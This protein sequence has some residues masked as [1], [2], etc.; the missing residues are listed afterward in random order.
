[1][2][3]EL[4]IELKVQD[5][6][7]NV[8]KKVCR[9]LLI[10]MSLVRNNIKRFDEDHHCD[11]QGDDQFLAMSFFM[12]WLLSMPSSIFHMPPCREWS[13]LFSDERSPVFSVLKTLH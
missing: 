4:K 11:R 5:H 12:R 8:K 1:M 3:S 7:G 2:F 9:L 6:Y 13:F 10:A